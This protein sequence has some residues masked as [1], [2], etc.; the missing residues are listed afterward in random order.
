MTD[1]SFD[2]RLFDYFL[3]EISKGKTE[4]TRQR[5]GRVMVRMRQFLDTVDVTPHLGTDP[6]SLLEIER[7]F[8]RHDAFLRVFD[9]TELVCCLPEF[10]GDALLPSHGLDARTQVS[11][12]GRLLPWLARHQLVDMCVGR[13]AFWD[14]QIAV[15][16]ARQRL[17][18][19]QSS[20][21][22]PLP[23][24]RTSRKFNP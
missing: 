14:A 1:Y 23:T 12:I 20:F 9:A 18:P 19:S 8:G 6:A 3:T 16:Q 5:Y 7:D 17:I 11:V 15:K 22:T 21:V 13:G 4:T 24:N 10:V 2:P